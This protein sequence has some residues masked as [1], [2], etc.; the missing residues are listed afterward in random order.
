MSESPM[1]AI[2]AIE[3]RVRRNMG[4]VLFAA[5]WL[6]APIYGGLLVVLAMIAVKFVQDLVT[7]VPLVLRMTTGDLILAA[8]T[9]VDL[10]LV[11]NLV[12]I[13][14]FAGWPNFVGPLL[15]KPGERDTAWAG[16]LDFCAVK[17]KL[18]GSVA[19]IAAIADPGEL[20]AYRCGTETATPPGNWRSCSASACPAGCWRRWTGIARREGIAPCRS[21]SSSFPISARGKNPRATTGRRRCSSSRWSIATATAMSGRSST[22]STPM[23]A[24]APTRWCSSPPPRR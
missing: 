15:R 11:A 7:E 22:T 24:T 1:P 19:A 23:A 3:A 13:V 10:S 9:L 18:I 21:A 16:A 12:V 6:V 20:R 17:L 14:I 8:L 5:R 2:H 4:R